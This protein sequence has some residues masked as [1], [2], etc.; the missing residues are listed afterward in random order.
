MPP[1][2]SRRAGPGAWLRGASLGARLV[3][4][5]TLLTILAVGLAFA[6]LSVQIR[7][8]TRQLL[9]GTLD[10][11]QA[12]LL[13]IRAREQ[14]NLLTVSR[15]MTESPTL[16]AA[17]ET[18]QA[19]RGPADRGPAAVL[20]PDL[21]ATIQEEAERIGADLDRDLLVITNADGIVLAA[22]ARGGAPVATG[23]D[24][25]R[26]AVIQQA[27]GDAPIG[28]GLA[29][30]EFGG[31]PY[32]VG[33][34]P[35]VLQ[36]YTI[37]TLSVGDA[38]DEQ[39][40]RRLHDA[41]D[42]EIVLAEGRRVLAA[43]LPGDAGDR[44]LGALAP[45]GGAPPRSGLAQVA[46]EEY[47]TAALPLADAGGGPE[48]TLYLVSSLTRALD[49]STRLLRRA[50]LLYGTLAAAFAGLAAWAAS[51]S[52][53]RP[54]E[55]FIGFLRAVAKS[56]DHARRFTEPAAGPEMRTLHETYDQLMDS[57][58]EYEG[59]RLQQARDELERV[60]RL[61]E[62][63]KLAALGRMLSGAAHEINNPLT[64]VLGNIDLVLG[65]ARLE[66]GARARLEKVR[67]EGQRIVALVRNLLKTAHRDG[68][69]RT[70]VDLNQLLRDCAGLRRHDFTTA[71]MRL[72]L[73]LAEA[74]CRVLG[75]E[76]ELQQVF[77]NIVNNAYDALKDSGPAPE[78]VV[79]TTATDQEIAVEFLDNGPG[80]KEP[81]RVF[82]NFYTTKEVG[83]G[84]GLGLAISHAIVQDHGGRI[85][86]A[87]RP[88]GGACFAITLPALAHEAA[89]DPA[90]QPVAPASMAARP[91]VAP[92]PAAVLV[93][94][95]EPTVL[96]LE[97]TILEMAG[98]TAVGA[99]SGAEA[100]EQL[101][102]RAFDL[103]VSDLKMPGE[104]TGEGLFRWVEANR[105]AA[106]LGFVFVTGDTVAETTHEFLVKTGRPY[107]QKPFSI[108]DYLAALREAWD[109]RLAA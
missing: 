81:Q 85:A 34:V 106:A 93:V 51:R 83:K 59:R 7:H 104:I 35:I 100:I 12:T 60:E 50:F 70:I 49:P 11:H 4:S 73:D 87:N 68:A 107:V 15:L 24:L 44:V 10:R 95:D 84:T 58:Q 20:R 75:G 109:E 108:E 91:A 54:F 19:E 47:V 14:A 40:A 55:G 8:Q 31:R 61:K 94:D 82:E 67:R 36:D 9:T 41:L 38:L 45:A 42:S 92:L 74:K 29:V 43:T 18:Y 79:R 32:Q 1:K 76:L 98:A 28:G 16:R 52:V 53:L 78:L 46:G 102:A 21:L 101:K 30:L 80:M 103:V 64:G 71:G 99:R 6:A 3:L 48:A 39:F 22:R 5:S 25:S 26:A 90:S 105:P 63:E 77:V 37:G 17:M 2:E 27:L 72:R 86:A 97:L 66:P 96:E 89:P 56:G 13:E 23:S 69:K 33:C 62:S 65:D 88:E 57:L